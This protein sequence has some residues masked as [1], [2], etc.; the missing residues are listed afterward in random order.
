LAHIGQLETLHENPT[1]QDIIEE[2]NLKPDV[3]DESLRTVEVRNWINHLVLP[4]MRS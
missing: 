3:L 1:R 4:G 2:L